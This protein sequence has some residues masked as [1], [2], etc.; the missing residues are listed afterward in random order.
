M[1]AGTKE[2]LHS[3]EPVLGNGPTYVRETSAFEN[4]T[5]NVTAIALKLD[6]RRTHVPEQ[7]YLLGGNGHMHDSTTGR[8]GCVWLHALGRRDS[9]QPQ[10]DGETLLRR[11]A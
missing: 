2:R 11:S 6:R 8:V 4:A 9:E 3:F 10:A 1:T 5:E 7:P